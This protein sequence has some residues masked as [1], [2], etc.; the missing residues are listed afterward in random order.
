MA[1]TNLKFLTGTSTNFDK[2]T[3]STDRNGQVYFATDA[4]NNKSYLYLG[5]GGKFLNI[6]PKLLT[7]ANG[8]TGRATLTSGYALIG[9]GTGAVSLR[10]IVN[11]VTSPGYIAADTTNNSLITVNALA[12][13]N[14]AHNSDGDSAITHLGTVIKG[15]WS[16]D[17]IALNKGGTGNTSFTNGGVVYKHLTD[18]KLVSSAQG[19]KGTI[20][21][22]NAGAPT[23]VTPG[24]A[25][26][27]GTTAG[28]IIVL[29]ING[30]EYQATIPAANGTTASGIV[31]AP[32]DTNTDIQQFSGLK[33]FTR[34]LTTATITPSADSYTLGTASKL[35]GNIYTKAITFNNAAST[36]V[37]SVATAAKLMTLN[38]GTSAGA[39]GKIAL[40]NT[41]NYAHNITSAAASSDKTLS[42]PNY[43]GNIVIAN[44]S[45]FDTPTSTTVYRIPVFQVDKQYVS[46]LIGYSAKLS[47][48]VVDLL[49]GD[50]G[51]TGS[52]SIYNG[53]VSN[54]STYSTIKNHSSNI[55]VNYT[56]TLPKLNGETSGT[57][58]VTN[59][60]LTYI[61]N[62]GAAI[63]GDTQPVY[64]SSSGRIKAVTGPIAVSYGGTGAATLTSNGVL[65]GS[66]IGAIKAT[67]ASTATGQVLYTSASGG[68]PSFGALALDKTADTN[69]LRVR[70]AVGGTDRTY[71]DLPAATSTAWGVISDDA[72]SF[73]GLKTFVNGVSVSTLSVTGSATIGGDLDVDGETTTNSLVV[74]SNASIDGDLYV[75]GADFKLGTSSTDCATFTYDASTDTLT[76][77]F[78]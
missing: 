43:S 16:A 53:A 73:G 2:L 39:Q 69:K 49:L 42:I 60:L 23:F 33:Q 70:L 18:A 22:G 32:P 78:P 44:T 62:D 72:Q 41:T 63:G 30:V 67:A 11:A 19:A 36:T 27:N 56:F 35:W 76:L 68:A 52:L 21:D 59:A 31:T 65:Y 58:S 9:N 50:S 77:N 14:G 8:G 74:E 7:A 47:D 54:A 24:F 25:W 75:Y 64:V 28:P 38:L 3:A 45:D 15:T 13:W 20:L 5:S 48:T 6:V 34:T 71:T 66:G 46:S 1:D 57:I 51:R 61:P 26:T 17:T 29:T 55:N 40:Y 10:K 12:N 37:G 4:T